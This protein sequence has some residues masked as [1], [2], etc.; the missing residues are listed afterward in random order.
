MGDVALPTPGCPIRVPPGQTVSV[1]PGLFVA[2]Y[3]GIEARVLF[4][5]AGHEKGLDIFRNGEDIYKYM[6]SAIFQ[7]PVSEVDKTLHR[8]LGK[9]GILGCGYQMGW[10]KFKDSAAD[11]G[12]YISAQ[13]A[14]KTVDTYREEHKPVK[15]L[16]YNIEKAAIE[17]VQRPGRR[18]KVNKVSFYMAEGFLV[19]EL[20]SG[21]TLN[22]HK[23]AI[24][25]EIPPWEKN[26]KNPEKQPK[27]YHWGIHPKTKQWVFDSTYGGKLVENI[28]QAIAR[29][30]MAEAMLRIDRAG[31]E[32]ILSV[33]DEL[34]S[35]A[36]LGKFSLEYY[37][38]LMSTLPPWATGCPVEVE[39]WTGY[40]YRK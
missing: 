34:V 25:M 17:A 32:I 35:E 37:N 2:D 27:L 10:K 28:V 24:K 40:R 12:L 8:P 19:C 7:I 5:L 21:R 14:K 18:V 9:E 31:F 11:K 15:Q 20:P 23:P 4:W 33:H 13:L 30:L 3:A 39:G 1:K 16:W 38:K 26:K 29:D 22:Y 6:A 36:K